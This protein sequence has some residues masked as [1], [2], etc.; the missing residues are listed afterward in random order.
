MTTYE[1]GDFF[2]P[3]ENKESGAQ[4]GET[5]VTKALCDYNTSTA[6]HTRLPLPPACQM[7]VWGRRSE[8]TRNGLAGGKRGAGALRL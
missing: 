7:R 1:V 8:T 2:L 6:E 4:R 5:K 3:L